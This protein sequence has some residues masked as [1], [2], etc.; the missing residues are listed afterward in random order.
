MP[1]DL[2]ANSPGFLTFGWRVVFLHHSH[3]WRHWYGDREAP[4]T[5]PIVPK[6]LHSCPVAWEGGLQ[7]L[8]WLWEKLPMYSMQSFC[9][10]HWMQR[11]CYILLMHGRRN[12]VGA[13]LDNSLWRRIHCGCKKGCTTRQCKCVKLLSNA[14]P[15]VLVIENANASLC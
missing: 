7:M 12:R 3:S 4:Q 11:Q 1:L 14:L 15:F 5:A 6:L 9:L 2:V 13:T 10:S 8:Q